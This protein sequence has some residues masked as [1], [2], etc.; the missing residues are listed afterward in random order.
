MQ[1]FARLE[2]FRPD[3]RHD[4]GAPQAAKGTDGAVD[5]WLPLTPQAQTSDGQ[6]FPSPLENGRE[7]EGKCSPAEQIDPWGELNAPSTV[8]EVIQT[9]TSDAPDLPFFNRALR[10]NP[11][12]IGFRGPTKGETA[13]KR[14]RWLM[15]LAG[16]LLPK[17]ELSRKLRYFTELFSEYPTP[18][19]F[20]AL[21]NLAIEGASLDEIE[22]ACR[23]KCSWDT[24][25]EWWGARFRGRN[26]IRS[27]SLGW[28]RALLWVK[29][30]GG[31][32]ADYIEADWPRAWHSLRSNDP[33]AWSF[34][35]FVESNLRQQG[36]GAWESFG[37]S[38]EMSHS[39]KLALGIDDR[40]MR[41][42]TGGLCRC[43]FD[44]M[45]NTQVS[46]IS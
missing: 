42:R 14:A 4:Q 6:E 30:C 19:T 17:R 12:E 29:L 46:E 9:R 23:F 21:S 3:W 45:P 13:Y 5:P 41:S 33:D 15:E 28:T 34:A 35:D 37:Y 44:E 32:P 7:E 2:R 38:R 40:A 10:T 8:R 31:D 26:Y 1:R 20:R 11:F 24:K 39:G 43:R 36:A 25:S 18:A 27:S 16:P 22:A